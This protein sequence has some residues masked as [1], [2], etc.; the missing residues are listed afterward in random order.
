MSPLRGS[1]KYRKLWPQ[2][3]PLA[4][5][6][7]SASLLM[8]SGQAGTEWISQPIRSLRPAIGEEDGVSSHTSVDVQ[9]ST[10][11]Q[12]WCLALLPSK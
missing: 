4:T 2:R 12:P 11:M 9:K 7:G 3:C 10:A 1:D 5:S 6:G 8:C